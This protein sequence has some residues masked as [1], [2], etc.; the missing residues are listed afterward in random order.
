MFNG[1]YELGVIFEGVLGSV[2]ASYIFYLI[3]VHL[4]EVNDKKVVYPH[5]I[6]WAELIVGNCKSQL[7]DFGK[8]SKID[9]PFLSL[10]QEQVDQAFKQINPKSNAPLYFTS[11]NSANWLQYF[12]Y[13]R[14]R[15][16][17]YIAKI[18]SQIIFI[19]ANLVSL[20]TN[21]DNC[22]HFDI[23]ETLQRYLINNQDLSAFSESFYKYC[24]YCRELDSYLENEPLHVQKG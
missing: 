14:V 5:I 13:Y 16:Q 4:K 24:T 3:V 6:K 2:L 10:T 7:S 18:M 12:D 22:N 20:I 19:D 8:E 21:I 15:S 23:V 11:N 17:K 1:A 9:L